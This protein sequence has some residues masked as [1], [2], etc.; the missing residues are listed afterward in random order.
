VVVCLG[1][2]HRNKA[3]DVMLDALARL[4]EHI[5][6]RPVRVLMVGDG[7]EKEAL[8]EQDAK[9]V[10]LTVEYA[11]WAGNQN[12]SPICNWRMCSYAHRGTNL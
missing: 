6:S 12:Q 8:H 7:P 1:R 5:Q 3:Y 4:P 2:L 10:E 11:G 9:K